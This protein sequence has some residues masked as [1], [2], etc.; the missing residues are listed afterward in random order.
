MARE[1]ETDAMSQ[2][3]DENDVQ[4]RDLWPG[5]IAG[6]C[7][8][9]GEPVLPMPADMDELEAWAYVGN[10]D[11]D[12]PSRGKQLFYRSEGLERHPVKLKLYGVV[13][14]ACL[15]P[16]GNWR[17]TEDGTVAAHRMVEL[18]DPTESEAFES[19]MRV[20][21]CLRKYVAYT[22]RGHTAN[23]NRQVL[24]LQQRLF[25]KVIAR[26]PPPVSTLQ[27]GDDPEGLTYRVHEQWVVTCDITLR[28][29]TFTGEMRPATSLSFEAGDFVEAEVYVDV[30]VRRSKGTAPK[31]VDTR[32]R[33]VAVTKLLCKTDPSNPINSP[34]V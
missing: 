12:M 15:T 33:V 5:D 4:I 24:R 30:I 1:C 32:F 11:D 18:E 34:M 16:L 14:Q 19:Q 10:I 29:R 20:L 8:E 23:Q 28:K 21:D 13:R 25:T 26:L 22:L 27:V 9:E 3:L 17:G 7:V 6:I 31:V 2:L